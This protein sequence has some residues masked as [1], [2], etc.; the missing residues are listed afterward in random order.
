R[1]VALMGVGLMAAGCSQLAHGTAESAPRPAS[2]AV[3]GPTI[4]QALV[5]GEALSQ[6]LKQRM[7]LDSRFPPQFGG[8]DTLQ[9]DAMDASA[10]C[11]GVA[12]ML[13]H[14]VYAPG[15]IQD[16]AV[17]TWRH[18]VHE[19]QVTGVKEAVVSLPTTADA[20][21]LFGGLARA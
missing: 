14:D 15:K 16:V 2:R 9:S 4:Q 18:E 19:T 21:A 5:G 12:T 3:K 7:V 1:A 8:P 17:E 13:A 20:E 10:G 11:L 6:I